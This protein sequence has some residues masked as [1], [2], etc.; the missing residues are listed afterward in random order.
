M[1]RKVLKTG[2]YIVLGLCVALILVR[3]IAG[4]VMQRKF[5]ARLAELRARG[6][7]LTIAEL[8]PPEIP[9][10]RNAA[11]LYVQAFQQMELV[12]EKACARVAELAETPTPLSSEQSDE[13][14][15]LLEQGKEALRL[16]R[17]GTE[18]PQCRFPVDA[19]VPAYAILLPHLAKVRSAERLFALSVRVS[20]AEGK[21]DAAPEDCTRMLTLAR[22]TH[23]EPFLIS[24]LVEIASTELALKQLSGVMDASDPS[25]EVLRKMGSTL[26]DAE[27]RSQFVQDMRAERCL[28]L[29]GI[30][31]AIRNPK[32]FAAICGMRPALCW[33][34]GFVFR[35]LILNDGLCYLDVM[36]R[37][38]ELAKERS[39]QG[40]AALDGLLATVETLS[41]SHWKHPISRLVLPALAR[42]GTAFDRSIARK[43]C[44]KLALALRLYRMKNE[45]YPEKL[46]QLV[47][48]FLDKLPGDPFSGKDFLY[49]TEGKGFIVYSVGANLKDDGGAE[50]A[51]SRDAG[52]IVWKCAR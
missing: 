22:S 48:D 51:L 3:V 52:D 1:L 27:D 12:S 28:G 23:D 32:E 7:P 50:D 37:Y 16:L 25:P 18:R 44:A 36:D 17:E 6:E 14:H 38:L 45:Q 40:K 49:R 5:N 47:P 8:V 9:A 10:D 39:W 30:D 19:S 46:S 33:V 13:A 35:P 29:S 21:M 11:A 24:T 42:A 31:A 20:L 41:K 34:L 2:G 4:V 43:G 15:K 26:G